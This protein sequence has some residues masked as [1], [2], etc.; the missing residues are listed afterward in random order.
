MLY[1]S[2]NH[3]VQGGRDL[4]RCLVKPPAQSRVSCG[5]GL[6]CSR[7]YPVPSCKPLRMETEQPLWVNCSTAWF[8]SWWKSFSLNIVWISLVST[9]A[10]C[11]SSS[12]HAL[13][14][15]AWLHF[16]HSFPMGMGKL[17]LGPPRTTSSPCWRI[18]VPSAF[19]HRTSA[20]ASDHLGGRLL[21]FL[22]F[23]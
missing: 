16:L 7:L 14:W 6:G 5:M 17:P 10:H 11:V 8:S 1:W 12:C 21:N 4:R 20:S 3:K 9:Y 13:L 15:R 19:S 23:Y 18:L 2:Q 22:W